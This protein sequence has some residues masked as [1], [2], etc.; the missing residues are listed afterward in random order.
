MASYSNGI[1]VPSEFNI[2]K[3][4]SAFIIGG[5]VVHLI[6]ILL[7]YFLMIIPLALEPREN[8][9]R[10]ISSALMRPMIITCGL[11]S[12][13][14]FGLWEKKKKALILARDTKIQKDKVDEVFKSMK[15]MTGFLAEHIAVHN[16]EILSW[17]ENNKRK[18]Q[19]VS[20]KV[21]NPN[22]KIAQALQSFSKI[23]FVTPYSENR[24]GNIDEI[25]DMLELKLNE[26][27]ELQSK[28]KN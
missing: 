4:M 23:S 3:A 26:I 17:I 9:S 25:E 18:G 12:L 20:K 11:F 2:A 28:R 13:A 21:E 24:P 27:S 8:F 7:D 16:S 10:S 15:R 1:A 22:K 14:I 5:I 6:V 19:Q